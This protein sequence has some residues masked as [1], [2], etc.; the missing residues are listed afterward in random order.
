MRKVFAVFGN[1]VLH[2]KS[3]QLFRAMIEAED[4]YVRIRPQS[5]DDILRIV[6]SL[7]IAGASVTSP[8]KESLLP[9][10]DDVTASAKAVGA[11]NCIR[12]ENGR[13]YGHNTDYLG[14]TGALEEAGMMLKDA[15]ILV[16]GAGGAARAAIYGLTRA[17]SKV[18]VSNRTMAKAK[19]LAASFGVGCID[20]DNPGIMPFFDA[21]VSTLL[22]KGIP[23]F[24]GYLSYG[25][26]LDAV[27]KPSRMSDFSRS[28]GTTVIP[29]DRWLIYQGLAAANFYVNNVR[30]SGQERA[31]DIKKVQPDVKRMEK[32]LKE[33]LQPENLRISVLDEQTVAHPI[34]AHEDLMVSGFGLDD[35]SIKNIID[36]EKHLAFGG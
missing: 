23:P 8:Y 18:F 5:S 7:K 35:N 31:P 34:E 9:L 27:Y 26:L 1:P 10:L 33:S 17:G 29:G 4:V 2:S 15:R 28:R 36:E 16:L 32:R 11:V 12:N 25:K 22:P 21:V 13:I 24:A 14:V 19:E 20:W 3:P 30:A 6:K